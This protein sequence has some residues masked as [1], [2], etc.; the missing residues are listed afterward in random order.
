MWR[1]RIPLDH[2]ERLANVY[3]PLVSIGL[4][5]CWM[6]GALI[7]IAV[8]TLVSLLLHEAGLYFS[9]V[10]AGQTP[11]SFGTITA[12]V[13]GLYFSG[14]FAFF[15]ATLFANPMFL[16]RVVVSIGGS[17]WLVVRVLR[18]RIGTPEFMVFC[19]LFSFNTINI[20]MT[21]AGLAPRAIEQLLLPLTEQGGTSE[22]LEAVQL[23]GSLSF[24]VWVGLHAVRSF[25]KVEPLSPWQ[26][27]VCADEPA[28][29]S[30]WGKIF[31]RMAGAPKNIGISD[32]KLRTA[33][34]MYFAN[35]SSL[36]PLI[37]VF[38]AIPGGSWPLC[39]SS[40][41]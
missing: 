38:G 39:P 40:R 28:P 10:F 18:H 34:L 15:D 30:G 6:F 13:I 9:D 12:H 11:T 33:L 31:L 26:I 5:N 3:A 1:S 35:M 22:L 25:F 37:I 23:L 24:V 20:T 7:P 16:L 8:V 41:R 29:G 17:I 27:Q 36:V 4:I 14:Q 19:A 2:A 32:R 21:L